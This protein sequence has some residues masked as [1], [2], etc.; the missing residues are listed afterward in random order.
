MTSNC[1]ER[2]YQQE[3]SVISDIVYMTVCSCNHT[4]GRATVNCS[5]LRWRL[6]ELRVMRSAT[7]SEGSTSTLCVMRRILQIM[8]VNTMSDYSSCNKMIVIIWRLLDKQCLCM[9]LHP[10]RK[11]FRNQKPKGTDDTLHPEHPV[12]P[13]NPPQCTPATHLAMVKRQQCLQHIA[14]APKCLL[15]FVLLA[16]ITLDSHQMRCWDAQPTGVA[17]C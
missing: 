11:L 17:V 5:K 10:Y 8:N 6:S 2:H 4:W 3:T 13:S 12:H 16:L 1:K 14:G 7:E 15:L 9:S